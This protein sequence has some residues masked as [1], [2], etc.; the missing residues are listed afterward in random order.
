[1]AYK[2]FLDTSG[3]ELETKKQLMVM[4]KRIALLEAENV[5]LKKRLRDVASIKGQQDVQEYMHKLD[6][7]TCAKI[8][9]C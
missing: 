1:M 8:S 4:Q 5:E 7:S 6:V 9:Q 2:K 3:K